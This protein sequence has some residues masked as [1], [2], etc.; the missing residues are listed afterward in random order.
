MT[1]KSASQ[2]SDVQIRQR[3]EMWKDVL[4]FRVGE[5]H[6]KEPT[7]KE[8][9]DK[10]FCEVLDNMREL[11]YHM[12]VPVIDTHFATEFN[13]EYPGFTFGSGRTMNTMEDYCDFIH[14]YKPG[15]SSGL[16]LKQVRARTHFVLYELWGPGNHWAE[17]G[18]QEILQ[19][20]GY[21]YQGNRMCD[22]GVMKRKQRGGF[23]KAFLVKKLDMIRTKVND[24]WERCFYERFFTRDN[25][26]K[27]KGGSKKPDKSHLRKYLVFC[28]REPDGFDGGYMV[29]EGHAKR[30]EID[31]MT[32]AEK[33]VLE[34]EEKRK[35]L[36]SKLSDAILAG[37]DVTQLLQEYHRG[38]SG[39]KRQL[40]ELPQ[41]Q[42]PATAPRSKKA[43]TATSHTYDSDTSEDD[44]VDPTS[45]EEAHVASDDDMAEMENSQG[46]ILTVRIT[47]SAA[48]HFCDFVLLN[49]CSLFAS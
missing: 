34:E 10:T 32:N 28:K 29:C 14:S 13:R 36:A 3:F 12:A 17:K 39:G 43:R 30:K 6:G 4:D 44:T 19:I 11:C 47:H 33:K 1:L 37:E 2:L 15:D 38:N 45:T 16:S 41:A 7:N 20:L 22:G 21:E 48:L 9:T 31:G 23:L 18:E 26:K 25:F 8:W 46:P 35:A 27:P 49:F 24:A 5:E 40:L 42:F